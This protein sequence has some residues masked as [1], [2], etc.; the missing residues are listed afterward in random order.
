MTSSLAY[1]N[2]TL[3]TNGEKKVRPSSSKTYMSISSKHKLRPSFAANSIKSLRPPTIPTHKKNFH[4]K[5]PSEK[6]KVLKN[7]IV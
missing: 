6:I 7:C 5:R 2:Q 4:L 3:T 1:K